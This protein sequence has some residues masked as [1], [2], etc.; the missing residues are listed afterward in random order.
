MSSFLLPPLL[1]I[2]V[3]RLAS[4]DQS[5]VDL[6]GTTVAEAIVILREIL[7]AQEPSPCKY[8]LPRHL[9][10][11]PKHALS[12][13]S[14]TPENH[15]RPWSTLCESCKRFEACDQ[16]GTGQRWMGCGRLGRWT[17]YPWKTPWKEI[18]LRPLDLLGRWTDEHRLA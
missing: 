1:N 17:D 15:N 14:Q 10:P 2:V 8:L 3:S 12:S 6:H 7:R 4:P 11:A 9:N 5:T 16:E 18:I 13:P